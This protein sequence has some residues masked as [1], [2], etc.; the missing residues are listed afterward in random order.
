MINHTLQVLTFGH[1]SIVSV[2]E[3]SMMKLAVM[4]IECQNRS[5]CN[6][7]LHPPNFVT[8]YDDYEQP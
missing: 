5:S 3:G 7:I 6:A 2:G 8:G 1:E 4:C